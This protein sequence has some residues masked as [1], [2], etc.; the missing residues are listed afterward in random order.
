MILDSENSNMDAVI[1]VVV[2][3]VAFLLGGGLAYVVTR[4]GA[5]SMTQRARDEARILIEEA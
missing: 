5:G 1:L 2:G 4:Q 3:V